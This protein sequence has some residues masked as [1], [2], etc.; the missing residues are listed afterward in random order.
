MV[1]TFPF[2]TLER[3]DMEA[4]AASDM[5]FKGDTVIGNGV[6]IGQNV[7]IFPRV[8]IGDGPSSV[9]TALWAVMLIPI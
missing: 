1:T 8:H 4:P 3:W 5:P 7:V 6:W 9:Q 2:Y